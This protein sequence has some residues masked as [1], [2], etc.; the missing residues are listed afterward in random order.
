MTSFFES[1][2]ETLPSVENQDTKYSTAFSVAAEMYKQ[3][4]DWVVFFREVL[5]V[6]GLLRRLF[7]TA[8]EYAEFEKSEEYSAIQEMVRRLRERDELRSTESEPTRVVTV[9]M[10]KS[11]H[12]SLKQEAGRRRISVNQLCISVLLQAVE[13]ADISPSVRTP[14]LPR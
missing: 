9:R 7:R 5:G 11:M 1:P 6:D 3:R 14:R 10:P 4:P 8:A 2:V 12:E 13:G